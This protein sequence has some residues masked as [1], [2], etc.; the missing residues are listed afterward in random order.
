MFWV[1]VEEQLIVRDFK[2]EQ[3]T[4]KWLTGITKS[5]TKSINQVRLGAVG[6]S[7]GKRSV[8]SPLR[9]RLRFTPSPLRG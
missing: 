1:M 2:A 8:A 9:R 5:M 3:P 7:S 4:Q 6:Q